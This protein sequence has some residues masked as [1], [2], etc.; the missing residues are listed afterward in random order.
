MQLDTDS[1]YTIRK[2]KPEPKCLF[3]EFVRSFF[4]LFHSARFLHAPSFQ[5]QW[6]AFANVAVLCG[7]EWRWQTETIEIHWLSGDNKCFTIQFI[8]Y[9]I[10][11]MFFYSVIVC[12][13]HSSMFSLRIV[14]TL[15]ALLSASPLAF[16][17]HASICSK[18]KWKMKHFAEYVRKLHIR[19][20]R[21]YR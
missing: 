3:Y 6:F 1:G 14:Y 13:Y 8:A 11:L 16:E 15:R 7:T 19:T 4:S 5:F 9:S 21:Y 17:I 10:R 2:I 20:D 18:S 12:F